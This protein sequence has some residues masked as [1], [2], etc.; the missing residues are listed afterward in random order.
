M[1]EWG[2]TVAEHAAVAAFTQPVA[3]PEPKYTQGE[4][5][6]ESGFTEEA[7]E[8]EIEGRRALP[9]AARPADFDL[10]R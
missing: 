8:A 2:R 9:R 7:S 10:A 4:A 1:W 6:A 5:T 3:E